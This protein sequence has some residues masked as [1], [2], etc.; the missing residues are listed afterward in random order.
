MSAN[1]DTM[2]HVNELPWHGLSIDVTDNPP[3][4]GA[5]IIHA[6]QMDWTVGAIPMITGIH[7]R[8][9]NYHCIYRE[10]NMAVLGAVDRKSVV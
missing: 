1:I 8:V 4:S 2:I 7:E 10:D 6:G 5:E 3:K 9:E